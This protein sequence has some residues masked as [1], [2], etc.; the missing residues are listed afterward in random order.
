MNKR[1]T[2]RGAPHSAV[3]EQ[4]VEKH[5]ERII[6]FLENERS[7]KN[8]D[9]VLDFHPDHAHNGIDIRVTT[10][11]HSVVTKR[12]GQDIFMV[13]NEALDVVYNDLRKQKAKMIVNHQ[14]GVPARKL[15]EEE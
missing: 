6:K 4:H 9:I 8:I 2:F 7:P 1:I 3:I 12:E 14:Q 11:S 5:L 13:I 15:T 10:P